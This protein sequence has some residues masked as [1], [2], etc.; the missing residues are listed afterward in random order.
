MPAAALSRIPDGVDDRTAAAFG[1]AHR[2]AYHALRSVARVQ[3]GDELIV[4]GAGG[5]VG[6]AAVQLGVL[7]GASVTAVASS[8]EKLEVAA[9][10][11]RQTRRQP[12]DRSTCERALQESAARTVPTPSSTRSAATSSEPALA[13]AALRRPVRHRRLRVRRHP[14]HPAQPGAGQG[15]AG[16]GLPVSGRP[17]RRIRPQRRR[18]ARTA[19]SAAACARTSA[20]STRC[21]NCGSAAARRR[22]PRHRQGADRPH[23]NRKTVS[24]RRPPRT[25]AAGIPFRALTNSPGSGPQPPTA[26]IPQRNVSVSPTAAAAESSAAASA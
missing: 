8:A 24:G 18:T 13:I 11:R 4:L 2:T 15:R 21:R 20:R 19:A 3:P 14:P 5:G 16:P 26:I 17:P 10:L 25:F 7:L 12:H 6:L 22:R 1:V 23:L 9:A